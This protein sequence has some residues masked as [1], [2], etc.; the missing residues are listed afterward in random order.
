VA[1]FEGMGGIELVPIDEEL[2]SGGGDPPTE[3]GGNPR[4]GREPDEGS[5]DGGAPAASEGPEDPVAVPEGADAGGPESPEASFVTSA[6]DELMGGLESGS[7]APTLDEAGLDLEPSLAES[8]PGPGDGDGWTDD[9]GW[10][11]DPGWVDDPGPEVEGSA[12]PEVEGGAPGREVEGTEELDSLWDSPEDHRPDPESS[13]EGAEETEAGAAEV[14]EIAPSQPRTGGAPPQRKLTRA[15]T[16]GAERVVGVVALVVVLGAVVFFGWRFLSPVLGVGGSGEPEVVLPP[17]DQELVPRMRQLAGRASGRMAEDMLALPERAAIPEAP[18]EDWLAGISLAGASQY[19]NVPDYWNA[20]GDWVAAARTA[21]N[22]LFREALQAQL[23][24]ANLAASDSEA[25][26]D[27]ALA[28][29]Q[30]AGSDRRIVYDQMQEVA[31]RSLVL[32]EFLLANEDQVTYEPAGTGVSRDP[33]LEAVAAT[34]A[35]GDEMWDMVG[36]IT[37]AMD[38]L[39][40]LDRIDTERLLAVF[41]EKLEATAIR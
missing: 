33:A 11:D 40:Y 5:G 28:G 8:F 16:P 22:A 19:P 36:A 13:S 32:H 30:A 14:P 15:R 18:S 25:I 23:D 6:E 38:A 35:L 21:E 2:G 39:G 4:G 24:T 31:E 1:E 20:I 26:R 9:P 29:F 17:L 34:D 12:P 41:L 37:N 27:R 3:E 7:G 10:A